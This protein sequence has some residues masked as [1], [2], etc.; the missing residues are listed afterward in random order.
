MG[1]LGYFAYDR[2]HVIKT[3]KLIQNIYSLKDFAR[4]FLFLKKVQTDSK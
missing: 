3:Q 1:G 2:T 4:L